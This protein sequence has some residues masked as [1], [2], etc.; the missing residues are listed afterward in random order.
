[1]RPAVAQLLVF[2]LLG[3]LKLFYVRVWVFFHVYLTNSRK[4][5]LQKVTVLVTV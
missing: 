4:P 5:S 1:M 3:I 2:A